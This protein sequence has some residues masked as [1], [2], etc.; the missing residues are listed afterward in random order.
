MFRYILSLVL[1][2][3]VV[4]SYPQPV[5][6]N[7]YIE[8]E[9]IEQTPTYLNA[10]SPE[11]VLLVYKQQENEMDTIGM[12]STQVMNYYKTLRNI[13]ANNILVIELDTQIVIDDH[14][15]KLVQNGEI[16]RDT[17]QAW[18]DRF[19]TAGAT[20]HAWQYF[21]TYIFLPIQSYLANTIVNG[22]P[23]KNNIRYIVLCKGIPM[24][25]QSRIDGSGIGFYSRWN[26]ALDPLLCYLNQADQ[27]F[28]ILNLFGTSYSNHPNPYRYLDP[29]LSFNY[30]FENHHF[31]IDNTNLKL[32][33]LV[34]RLDGLTKDKVIDLINHSKNSDHSGEGT[35]IFDSHPFPT[36]PSLNSYNENFANA[37]SVL[38][39]YGFNS[40]YDNYS[41][42]PVL[43]NSNPILGYVSWGFILD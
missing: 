20:I 12:I 30:R 42:N 9:L 6:D 5:F 28:S 40:V 11:N 17:T 24:R 26:V 1:I 21:N 34:S 4:S 18:L 31:P 15:I 37:H 43:S 7:T 13:P 16:I 14:V 19:W 39:A 3:L 38:T 8:P 29:S 35:F 33:Y 10:P 32:S 27:Q 36:S 22:Y 41:P 2:F 25:I 23:L